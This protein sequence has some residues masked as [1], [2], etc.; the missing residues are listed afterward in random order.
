MPND[1]YYGNQYAIHTNTVFPI[2]DINVDTAWAVA[3]GDPSIKVGIF[4]SGIQTSHEDLI[5]APS[6][7]RDF[8]NLSWPYLNSD[9]DGHGTQMAGIIGATRNN[10][11]GVCGIAGRNDP[12]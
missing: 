5:E 8:S 9:V 12:P 10:V 7:G 1:W 3:H 11:L 6:G 4:D 2:A